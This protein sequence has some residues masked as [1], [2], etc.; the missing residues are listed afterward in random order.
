VAWRWISGMMP[1]RRGRGGGCVK[2]DEPEPFALLCLLLLPPRAVR[3]R[4]ERPWLQP[5]AKPLV[6]SPTSDSVT[7]PVELKK[8]VAAFSF[9][10]FFDSGAAVAG[11]GYVPWTAIWGRTGSPRAG[12]STCPTAPAPTLAVAIATVISISGLL[13]EPAQARS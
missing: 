7:A 8:T 5:G 11:G 13:A 2:T 9:S 10:F 12:G 6:G 4:C 1:H 3:V